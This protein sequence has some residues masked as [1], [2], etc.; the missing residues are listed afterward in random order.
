MAQMMPN[1]FQ[2]HPN[3][4]PDTNAANQASVLAIATKSKL[5]CRKGSVLLSK[6]MVYSNKSPSDYYWIRISFSRPQFREE[7]T[8]SANRRKDQSVMQVSYD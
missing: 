3:A 6:N 7:E 8:I 4:L 5:T 2:F 1:K